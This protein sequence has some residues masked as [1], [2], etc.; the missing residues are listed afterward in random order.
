M[1]KITTLF[2]LAVVM[3]IT[4]CSQYSCPTYESHYSYSPPRK[5]ALKYKSSASSKKT[6]KKA[7]QD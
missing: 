6:T 4:S 3:L 2:A 1:K 7:E 5:K